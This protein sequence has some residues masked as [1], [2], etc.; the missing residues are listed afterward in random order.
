MAL[1]VRNLSPEAIQTLDQVMNNDDSINTKTKA[2][3][4]V[5]VMFAIQA[6]HIKHLKDKN[7]DVWKRHNEM[8]KRVEQYDQIKLNLKMLLS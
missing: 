8:Q 2:I 4:H 6:E 7:F 1:T 5:L 3:E